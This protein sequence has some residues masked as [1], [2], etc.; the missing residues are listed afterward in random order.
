MREVKSFDLASGIIVLLS[1]L[2][3]RIH[4][5]YNFAGFPRLAR[6][7]SRSSS[8]PF[9]LCWT[10]GC[11][12]WGARWAAECV[13]GPNIGGGESEE[14][15]TGG[16][17]DEMEEF[18]REVGPA[19]LVAADRR[20]ECITSRDFFTNTNCSLLQCQA[21]VADA[22]ATQLFALSHLEAA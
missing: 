19:A 21:N 14:R 17:S 3:L 9:S 8:L 20:Q 1:D 2:Q 22:I 4:A 7:G 12:A 10:S 16:E 5:A 6:F 13:R 11:S 18:A 15:A